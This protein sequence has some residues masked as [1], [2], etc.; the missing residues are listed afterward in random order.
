MKT[1]D[2]KSATEVTIEMKSPLLLEKSIKEDMLL[3]TMH[4]IMIIPHVFQL[5]LYIVPYPVPGKTE[6]GETL[7]P[8]QTMMCHKLTIVPEQICH[9]LTNLF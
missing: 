2:N 9:K 6:T 7:V 5:V 4:M 8:E 1:I 3:Q